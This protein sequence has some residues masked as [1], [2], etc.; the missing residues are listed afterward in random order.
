MT[1]HLRILLAAACAIAAMPA[2][3]AEWR[4]AEKVERYAVSGE[5]GI[6]LYRSVGERGPKVGTGRVVAYTTF[7]LKWSRKYVPTGDSCTLASA[8]PHLILI[9][10]LPKPAGKLPA[11]T[12]KPWETFSTGIEAH[13]RVHGEIIV[14]MVRKIQAVSVGLT[15]ANDPE[16]Q[17]IRKELTSR[18]SRR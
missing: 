7:D 5:T 16:C 12:Q 14:D 8:R 4:A 17:K 11:A 10:K 1:K 3:G 18:P 6:A 9:Y 13:E 2:A 15:A